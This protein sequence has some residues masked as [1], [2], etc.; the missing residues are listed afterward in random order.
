MVR[1]IE[2]AANPYPYQECVPT[3]SKQ[4]CFIRQQV[5]QTQQYM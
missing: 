5:T 3:I 4:R 2:M 1:L